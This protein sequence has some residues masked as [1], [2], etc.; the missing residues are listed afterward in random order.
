MPAQITAKS[1][2][3][4][5]ERLRMRRARLIIEGLLIVTLVITLSSLWLESTRDRAPFL[6]H[7]LFVSDKDSLAVQGTW[8]LDDGDDAYPS[9]TTTIECE[10]STMGC[11]E[12]SAV[13]LRLDLMQA[14]SINRLKALRWDNDLIVTEGVGALCVDA[15]YEFRLRSKAVTGLQTR[16]NDPQCNVPGAKPETRLHMVDGYE[17][18]WAKRR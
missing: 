1:V 14:V 5:G 13:L 17:E 16:N 7:F 10:R 8:R 6:P 9:Q 15:V 4:L 2:L 12:A 3:G 18:S 11:I